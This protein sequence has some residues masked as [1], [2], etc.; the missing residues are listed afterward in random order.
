M[1]TKRSGIPLIAELAGVSIGTV[2]R[3]LHGRPGINDETRERVLEVAKKI[4]YRPNL[5]ARSL[6]TGRRVRI[7]VCVPREIRYFYNELWEGIHEEVRRY[8]DR[9][10]EFLLRPIPELGKGERPAFR[11]IVD[12]GVQGVVVTPGNPE[13]M[14][15]LIDAAEE[16]DIRVVCVSTDAP[17]SQ[18]SCIVCVEPRLNGL[19]A[20]ELMSKF[21]PPGSQVAIITGMLKTVDHREKAEG[22]TRS[23]SEFCRKGSVVATIEAHEDP[24]QS[25]RKTRKLLKQLPDIA[26]IYVN[27]VNCLPVCRALTAARRAGAVRLIATDLFREMVPYFGNGIIDASMH[28]RPYRQGQL[29]VRT[30]A[31]HLLH[32]ADLPKAHFLN[33]GIILRSN[34]HLFRETEIRGT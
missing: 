5:A 4:G 32:D 21:L 27:T 25:F 29:A 30:L 24:E 7:G 2:D 28:Q 18:R 6:S 10:I 31:E 22:F 3:A 13:V 33:P 11:K 20:G 19:I 17:A 9:G 14:T 23:F 26:G 34:L 8:A 15:P 1:K 12:S 16:A